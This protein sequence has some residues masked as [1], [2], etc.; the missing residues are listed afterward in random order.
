MCLYIFT[1]IPITD[2]FSYYQK[3]VIQTA[4][5]IIETNSCVRFENAYE[6][7]LQHENHIVFRRFSPEL[8][9]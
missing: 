6:E 8:K 4:L 5:Q 1:F 9:G 2:E 3:I 7:Q